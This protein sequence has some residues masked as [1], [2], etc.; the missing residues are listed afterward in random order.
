M[1][2]TKFLIHAAKTRLKLNSDYAVAP[3]LGIDRQ[4]VS[5]YRQRGSTMGDDTCTQLAEVLECDP[6]I[7]YAAMHAE[8]A[9]S[10]SARLVWLEIWRR[11]GG[12]KLLAELELKYPMPVI[13]RPI[14]PPHRL[15][16]LSKWTH[17]NQ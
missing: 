3:H 11:L 12:E 17:P 9:K 16:F 7:L 1:M 14:T 10:E 5:N 8:R 4:T 13:K 15:E 2:T 6:A